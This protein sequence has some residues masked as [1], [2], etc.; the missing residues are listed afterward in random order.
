MCYVSNCIDIDMHIAAYEIILSA[1]YREMH[2]VSQI[3]MPINHIM[4]M[5][6][7]C[8]QENLGKGNLRRF[9]EDSI[10]WKEV[11]NT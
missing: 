3:S 5:I 11:Y 7:I 6:I 1:L 10:F 9:I 2:C 8:S 4:I